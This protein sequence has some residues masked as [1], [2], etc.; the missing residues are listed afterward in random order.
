MRKYSLIAS[1]V[2]LYASQA[3]AQ[4]QG[5]NYSIEYVDQASNSVST[6]A[7]I[8]PTQATN[9]QTKT[10]SNAPANNFK[11]E[12]GSSNT[13][14]F[15]ISNAQVITPKSQP[16]VAPVNQKADV[17]IE[18]KNTAIVQPQ[19]QPT[20]PNNQLTPAVIPEDKLNTPSAQ[21][22]DNRSYV[23]D[24][25]YPATNSTLGRDGFVPVQSNNQGF[26]V[27]NTQDPQNQVALN[28]VVDIQEVS[29]PILTTLDNAIIDGFKSLEN[30]ITLGVGN[31]IKYDLETIAPAVKGLTTDSDGNAVIKYS[32]AKVQNILKSQG[33]VAWQGLSNPILIWLVGL[34]GVADSN[35]FS[36]VS[37][38]NLTAFAQAL[39]NNA[40]EFKYRVIFP[41]LDL[42]EMQKVKVQTVLD[43]DPTILTEASAR[44]GADYFIAAAVNS[45]ATDGSISFKWNLFNKEGTAIA[46]SSLTGALDEVAS[47]GSGDIARALAAWQ[48]SEE[49][50]EEETPE[51]MTANNVDIERLGPGD[52]FIR[53]KISNVKSLQDIQNIRQAFISYGYAGDLRVIGYDNGFM[54]IEFLTNSDPVILEGTMKRAGDFKYLSSWT[55]DLKEN[56]AQRQPF[57]SNV[58]PANSSRPNSQISNIQGQIKPATITPKEPVGEGDGLPDRDRPAIHGM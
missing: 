2:C 48:N 31:S 32:M 44:Y 18:S 52:G 54:I 9:V 6:V 26:T 56:I 58:G 39:L 29:V 45:T 13:N 17:S 50:K 10:V 16:T 5:V 42:E 14:N 8:A 43:N 7:P 37:G 34:D 15:S 4:E 22:I 28:N 21:E 38:Q 46:Q 51:K 55:F 35:S 12:A 36:L 33:T 41:I 24:Q 57:V 23:E 19:V 20:Q 3:L 1:L 47:L 40:P 49:G 25:L 11:I 30:S 27:E 53:M